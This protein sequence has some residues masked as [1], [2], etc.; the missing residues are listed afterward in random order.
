MN[1]YF[2]YLA[3]IVRHKWYVYL[4]CCKLGIPFLG[5]THDNSKLSFEEFVPYVEAFYG[6]YGYSF[7]ADKCETNLDL[8]PPEIAAAMR[9]AHRLT[10]E[11]FDVAWL[12]HQHRNP[13]HWQYWCLREDDPEEITYAIRESGCSPVIV[14]HPVTNEE[15][16]SIYFNVFKD[17]AFVK[18]YFSA[19]VYRDLISHIKIL[20]MP[21]RYCKEM[22]ADW[23]GASRAITSSDN[24]KVWYLK[25]R[26]SILLHPETRHW[27]EEQ[28]DITPKELESLL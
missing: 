23:R 10:M 3:Y 25:H 6:D 24:T 4:E 12:Y 13:H 11:L 17:S 1:K 18:A 2:K 9:A 15:I 5:I 28:L 21:D 22:L 8:I 7:I 16:I 14:Y 27:I 26:Y 20:R 19:R